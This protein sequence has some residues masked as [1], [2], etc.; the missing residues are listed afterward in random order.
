MGFCG[1]SEIHFEKKERFPL[2]LRLTAKEETL[3]IG[4]LSYLKFFDFKRVA[5]VADSTPTKLAFSSLAPCVLLCYIIKP[6]SFTV[7]RID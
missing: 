3:G 1:T 4:M 2:Y 6:Q 5:L 7:K